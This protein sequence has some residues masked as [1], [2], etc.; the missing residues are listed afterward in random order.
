MTATFF[1]PSTWLNFKLYFP[2]SGGFVLLAWAY[3]HYSLDV[4]LKETDTCFL[5]SRSFSSSIGLNTE[6]IGDFGS[7]VPYI[8]AFFLALSRALLYFSSSVIRYISWAISLG[9]SPIKRPISSSPS[10]SSALLD[11][12]SSLLCLDFFWN[13]RY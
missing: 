1:S 8:N 4:D 2:T 3:Y 10:E 13:A 5:I 11:F 9:F 7:L 12:S 6:E